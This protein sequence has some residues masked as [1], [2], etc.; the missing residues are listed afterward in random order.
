MYKKYTG[1]LP[2][3]KSCNKLYLK[4]KPKPTPSVCYADQPRG[5]NKVA[6][7]VKDICKIAGLDG[8]FTNHS[9]RATS[10]SRMFQS[11]VPEKIIK[12]ITGHKYDCVRTYKR[13]SDEIRQ[14]GSNIICSIDKEFA[15]STHIETCNTAKTNANIDP[16]VE[17]LMSE[18]LYCVVSNLDQPKV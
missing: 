9:L 1:L 11:E 14:K 6:N 17:S 18:T 15:S 10:A 8:K 13:T 3:T 12:E 5:I 16:V 2:N 4:V 7:I